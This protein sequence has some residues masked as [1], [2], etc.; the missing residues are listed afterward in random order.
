MISLWKM[1][2]KQFTCH[3]M[4]LMVGNLPVPALDYLGGLNDELCSELNMLYVY[5]ECMH[6]MFVGSSK[7]KIF[8]NDFIC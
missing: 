8:N 7:T 6:G 5:L 1:D 2:N 3:F 4:L